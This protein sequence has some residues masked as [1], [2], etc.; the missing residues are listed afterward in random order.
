MI[1]GSCLRK[2]F[3]IGAVG[4][5]YNLYLDASNYF[6]GIQALSGEVSITL[7]NKVKGGDTGGGGEE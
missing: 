7:K 2:G 4:L 3:G 6:R 5:R 1:G